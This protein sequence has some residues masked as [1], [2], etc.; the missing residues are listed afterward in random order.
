MRG[1][2]QRDDGNWYVRIPTGNPERPYD[3][4]SLKTKDE[5]EAKRRAQGRLAAY[6]A[7]DGIL[8]F[9]DLATRFKKEH[10]PQLRPGTRKTYEWAIVAL[11][12]TLFDRSIFDIDNAILDVF[13]DARLA[14][15][16]SR[17]GARSELQV[18]SS[19]FSFAEGKGLTDS[20][21]VVRYIKGHR[22]KVKRGEPRVR[23][24]TLAEET[25]MLDLLVTYSEGSDK[26]PDA[27]LTLL[28]AVIVAIDT[29]LRVCE[30]RQMEWKEISF[31]GNHVYVPKE[32][33][34]SGKDRWVPL[35]PRTLKLLQKMHA[36]KTCAWVFPNDTNTGHRVN[37]D[38]A[39]R[40]FAGRAIVRRKGEVTVHVDGPVI[41]AGLA[42]FSWHDLR[43]TC[44]CRLLQGYKLS[45]ERVSKW[46]GHS[47]ISV[48]ERHYAFLTVDDLHE[49]VGTYRTADCTENLTLKIAQDDMV[50][51][52]NS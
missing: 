38:K 35:L 23:W 21:P 4:L 47:S 48:T 16:I 41:R 36:N 17:S 43:R 29:G 2:Y 39:L 7:G 51:G 14:T 5:A 18:L 34:K 11:T 6:K 40:H 3:R 42:P 13:V 30:I 1:L 26:G 9:Q 32:R 19:M 46:L 15:G 33:A 52:V 25:Q 37:F 24:L 10:F 22:G 44:G 8:L 12:Q 20:N 49:A 27:R 45:M 50:D 31:D 28:R